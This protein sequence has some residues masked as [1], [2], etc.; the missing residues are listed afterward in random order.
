[1]STSYQF[2]GTR[3]KV[4]DGGVND[5]YDGTAWL[6]ALTFGYKVGQ[7]DLRLEGTW[8]KAEGQQGYFLQR[9]TPTY[10]S[11]NGRLD[12][13]WIT[14]PTS[15]PMAKKQSSSAQCMI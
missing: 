2:Y 14:V 4:S 6:Q 5:I 13:W 15:T 8:V 7:V 3:D 10:A 11:S 9:M 1:M 12:I